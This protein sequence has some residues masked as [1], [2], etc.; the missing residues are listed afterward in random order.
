MKWC[1]AG[2]RRALGLLGVTA[3]VGLVAA[4]SVSADADLGE[5]G[6]Y[7]YVKDSATN[8]GEFNLTPDCP[9]HTHIVGGGVN[10]GFTRAEPADGPDADRRPDDRW[11][12]RVHSSSSTT[13]AAFAICNATRPEYAR[14]TKPLQAGQGRTVRAVCPAGTKV[15]GGG[16]RISVPGG[17]P[18]PP[19]NFMSSSFPYDGNDANTVPDDGWAVS[20]LNRDPAI[21]GQLRASAICANLDP[22]YFESS[23]LLPPN[24]ATFP[25]MPC[26]NT[27]HIVGIGAQSVGPLITGETFRLTPEDAS[28]GPDD[29][30]DSVPDDKGEAGVGNSSL[31]SESAY[32]AFSICLN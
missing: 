16:A 7:F 8:S 13:L 11:K 15:I 26:P 25:I 14:R 27:H 9:S 6:G 4:P 23:G 20:A 22:L 17:S 18:G 19:F 29:D 12:A 30:L 2:A 21:A 28:G 5:S 1:A 10:G 24:S 3:A 32:N 31:V